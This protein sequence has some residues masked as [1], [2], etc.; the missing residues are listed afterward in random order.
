MKHLTAEDVQERLGIRRP[1][2]YAW[3][4]QGKLHPVR[5]GRGLLFEED[6]IMRLLG[7]GTSVALWIAGGTLEEAKS[8]VRRASRSAAKPSYRV[9]Y[10]E[11]PTPEF[12]RAKLLSAGGAAVE[13][14]HPGGAAFNDLLEAQKKGA[15]AFISHEESVW[16]VDDVRAETSPSGEPYLALDLVRMKAGDA[17][18][19]RNARL[20]EIVERMR[21]G[22]AKGALQP[23]RREDLYG[24]GAR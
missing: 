15:F 7:R 13:S 3:V 19:V 1:T 24:R 21:A 10:L 16:Q 17:G 23:Y 14:P 11:S 2:L 20:L 12:I 6:D 5:A 8:R 22:A 9:E 18:P 4:R